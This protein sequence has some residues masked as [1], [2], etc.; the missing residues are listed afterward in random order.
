MTVYGLE[1]EEYPQTVSKTD[2]RPFSKLKR[3]L[4]SNFVFSE[5]H[6]APT[7]PRRNSLFSFVI[8]ASGRDRLGR[9]LE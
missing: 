1:G 4:G 5:R 9:R 7:F 6:Y 8:P 2:G 3:Y